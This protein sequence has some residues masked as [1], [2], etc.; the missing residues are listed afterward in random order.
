MRKLHVLL[1][2]LFAGTVAAKTL[3]VGLSSEPR[4]GDPF[5]F[6]ET[7][8][9][10]FNYNIYD[11]L[12]MLDANLKVKPGLATSW[13]V[14]DARTIVFHLRKGVKFHDGTPFDA[15]DVKYTV[16][17]AKNWEK[18]QFKVY[19][20]PIKEVIVKDKYTVILKLSRPAPVLIRDL[21]RL[22]IMSKE[23]TENAKPE[24]IAF[25]PIGTGPYKFKEWVKG[26]HITLVANKDYWG[27]KPYFD[28]VILKPLTNDAA[29]TAALLSG[30]VDVIEH[31][32]LTDAERIAKDP[33]FTFLKTDGLRLIFVG[34]DVARDKIY[35]GKTP[36][37]KNPFKDV[38]VRK[39]FYYGINVEGIIKYINRGYNSPAS[40]YF[41]STVFGYD[42][43]IKREPY[44]PE[45]AKQLLKE[46]G[47]PNGFEVT[48]D[49]PNDRYINDEKV[50]AAIA[51]DLAKIGIKVKVNAIPK[52]VFFP[53]VNSNKTS[54]FLLG[55]SCSS[56]DGA[57]FFDNILHTR[58]KE[59]GYGRF[60]D[61]GYSNPV[62]DKLIEEQDTLMDQAK[63]EKIMHKITRLA[64]NDMAYIPLYYYVNLFAAKKGIVFT[65]RADH[66]M[67]YRDFRKEK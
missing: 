34:V 2:L 64:L 61:A 12:V 45:K 44:N 59:R 65:P 47:Y 19:F 8:T 63:R 37:G 22:R 46:A 33:R 15:E 11:A 31:V 21:R 30:A 56:A 49:A 53:M 10:S 1:A 50:A 5:A 32:P 54:F 3:V 24:D 7:P 9:N 26:D 20:K 28:K 62:V 35:K 41:P 29:R 18:S 36:D 23:S 42:P 27:P 58:D 14:K 13:E 57:A 48:L 39:A 38:R 60:N 17:R 67:Y 6:N 16:E 51:A 25:H 4:S 52:A 66:V 40:Q 55:W 43:T